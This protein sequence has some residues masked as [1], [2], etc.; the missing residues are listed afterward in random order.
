MIIKNATVC[1]K[2]QEERLDVRIDESK[3]VLVSRKIEPNADEKVIDAEGL[4]LMPS[5]IDLNVRVK[6]DQLTHKN[7]QQLSDACLKNG[8][9]TIGLM[10]NAT[11]AI[12]NEAVVEFV[13][14]DLSTMGRKAN[15]LP[16]C[17]GVT[18]EKML[19]DMSILIRRGCIGIFSY[20]NLKGGL[21][22][23]ISEYSSMWNVPLFCR[24]EDLSLSVN[25]V[26]NEGFLSAKLGLPGIPAIAETK[27]VAKMCEISFG[28]DSPLV[29]Q[30]IS[31]ERSV[32][33]IEKAKEEKAKV[34]CE[35]GIHHLALNE[36][37]CNEYNTY[38]KIKPPLKSESTRQKLIANVKDGHVDFITS[39]HA[40]KS[41]TRKDLAFETADF[42]ID[43][44]DEYFPVLYTT[45][46][47]EEQVSLSKM[48]ELSSY[49]QAQLIGLGQKGLID[50]GY[51]A[52]LMLVDLQHSQTIERE[53]TPYQG[54]KVNGKIINTIIMGEEV[55]S[56]R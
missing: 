39:A 47:K 56:A 15:I 4:Y 11:P 51:D 43:A 41:V 45:L 53:H 24:C 48:S 10:P 27:E 38:A 52:D 20:S 34:F 16:I 22:R 19:S 44:L 26:M 50:E 33:I 46:V 1:D 54:R 6:N 30:T 42:G 35:V 37:M 9:T 36:G 29:L 55:Y 40:A 14:A 31:S 18:E 21:L 28:T 17:R 13:Q 12:D 49:N 2:N 25:G 23:R 8:V 32:Q 5:M 3:I 7:L